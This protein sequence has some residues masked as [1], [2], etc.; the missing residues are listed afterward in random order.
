[1]KSISFFILSN[2]LCW[3][4]SQVRHGGVD[5]VSMESICRWPWTGSD[6]SVIDASDDESPSG[7]NGV[8]A[9]A[10]FIRSQFAKLLERS[11]LFRNDGLVLSD[12]SL[13]EAAGF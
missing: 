1:M 6:W 9:P 11:A 2:P 12:D 3:N 8:G 5:D 10:G 13:G 4:V 7:G